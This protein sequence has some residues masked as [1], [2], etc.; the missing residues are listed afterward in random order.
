MLGDVLAAVGN[1]EDVAVCPLRSQGF[2]GDTGIFNWRLGGCCT[3]SRQGTYVT[4][5]ICNDDGPVN[6][7]RPNDLQRL[8]TL[9]IK[10]SDISDLVTT[11]PS[12]LIINAEGFLSKIKKLSTKVPLNC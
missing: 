8:K 12:Q 7:G 6:S 4:C 9:N 1:V 10:C 3:G 5:H 11:S 2:G